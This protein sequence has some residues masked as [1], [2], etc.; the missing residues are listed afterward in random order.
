MGSRPPYRLGICRH[1]TVQRSKTKAPSLMGLALQGGPRVL[2]QSVFE[3]LVEYGHVSDVAF[4][5]K[6]GV[7]IKRFGTPF[8]DYR[9]MAKMELTEMRRAVHRSLFDD[10]RP[11]HI[12]PINEIIRDIL[13]VPDR[14][15]EIVFSWVE[16]ILSEDFRGRYDPQMLHLIAMIGD[17]RLE[18]VF[19]RLLKENRI[20]KEQYFDAMELLGAVCLLRYDLKSCTRLWL[21]ILEGRRSCTSAATHDGCSTSGNKLTQ[22]EHALSKP[23]GLPHERLILAFRMLKRVDQ[24]LR[25]FVSSTYLQKILTNSIALSRRWAKTLRDCVGAL[26]QLTT[27][28]SYC[29]SDCVTVGPNTLIRF[30]LERANSRAFMNL[31]PSDDIVKV[32]C[33][34]ERNAED[35]SA[36]PGCADLRNRFI[37]L[38]LTRNTLEDLCSVPVEVDTLSWIM[39]SLISRLVSTETVSLADEYVFRTLL[40]KGALTPLCGQVYLEFLQN[41]LAFRDRSLFRLGIDSQCNCHHPVGMGHSIP[42]LRC[43]AAMAV[44]D[45]GR[46]LKVFNPQISIRRGLVRISLSQFLRAHNG[47]PNYSE[48]RRN[49]Y[50]KYKA[51]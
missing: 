20:L 17:H 46:V 31:P 2:S 4:L 38:V 34:L 13:S 6:S 42:K 45:R 36:C 19:T 1:V 47:G 30:A 39:R 15:G 21:H 50:I 28:S 41:M 24:E 33:G 29:R 5:R 7:N 35:K 3:W 44:R 32:W 25:F 37:S 12:I 10:L 40:F 26:A 11:Y 8:C 16:F 14:S 23:A 18:S 27:W 22:L 48:S 49:L 51:L 43:L 9:Y